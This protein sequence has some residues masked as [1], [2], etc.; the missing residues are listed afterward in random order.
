MA[1]SF[2]IGF[3]KPKKDGGGGA[4]DG[5]AAVGDVISGKT[6]F[7]THPKLKL[8]GTGTNAKQY[9]TGNVNGSAN[10]ITVS[11]LTFTP[12]IVVF[13]LTTADSTNRCVCDVLFSG[14]I[15]YY[16]AGSPTYITWSDISGTKAATAGAATFSAGT[17]TAYVAYAGNSNFTWYA[18]E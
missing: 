16:G 11:G 17:F 12:R 9:A 18:F 4:L 10:V 6:F 13:W 1:S 5:N 8:T 14:T 2:N 7:A 3:V 15:P